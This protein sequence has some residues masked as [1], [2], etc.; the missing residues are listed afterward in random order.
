MK[1]TIFFLLI[2]GAISCSPKTG[3]TT[4]SP[5]D[6]P[7]TISGGESVAISVGNTGSYLY[8]QDGTLVWSHKG[9]S[10]EY[11]T[12]V[13]GSNEFLLSFKKDIDLSRFNLKSP[14]VISVF[15]YDRYTLTVKVGIMFDGKKAVNDFIDSE[16]K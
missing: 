12:R 15:N 1:H 3:A 14:G 2:I 16:K 9:V 13:Y 7:F 4:F 6:K 5:N 11:N 10:C 8:P